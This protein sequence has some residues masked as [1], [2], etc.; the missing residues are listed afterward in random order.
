MLCAHTANMSKRKEFNLIKEVFK[1]CA[2]V[3]EC[4][5]LS[6]RIALDPDEVAM[7]HK[8]YNETDGKSSDGK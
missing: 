3:N 6:Q 8:M 5:G 1:E 4:T 7:F 2:S